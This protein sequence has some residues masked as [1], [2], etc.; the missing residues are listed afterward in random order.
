MRASARRWC[1]RPN[2]ARGHQLIEICVGDNAPEDRHATAAALAQRTRS[3]LAQVIGRTALLY[4]L[5]KE[6]PAIVLPL[7]A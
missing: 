2:A 3:H 5:R 6:D 4:R 7:P 1:G